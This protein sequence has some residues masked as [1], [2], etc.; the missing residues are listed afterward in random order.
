MAAGLAPD[1]ARD[2]FVLANDTD[3]ESAPL[4]VGVARDLLGRGASPEASR[5]T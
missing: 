4:T 5:L 3:P 2:L 1:P